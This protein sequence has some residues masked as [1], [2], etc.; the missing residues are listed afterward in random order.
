MCSVS[1][2]KGYI[3]HTSPSTSQRP[4][5]LFFIAYPGRIVIRTMLLHMEHSEGF[6]CE[7][8]EEWGGE[9]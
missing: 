1:Q 4:T 3:D 8:L 2:V 9:Q 7:T 6:Q 5:A